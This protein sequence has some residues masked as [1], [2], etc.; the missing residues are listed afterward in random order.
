MSASLKRTSSSAAPPAKKQKKPEP[1][2][3]DPSKV[4]RVQKLRLTAEA[5]MYMWRN[6]AL[7]NGDDDQVHRACESIAGTN[8]ENH[9][10]FQDVEDWE[11][12]K[13]I[14]ETIPVEPRGFEWKSSWEEDGAYPVPDDAWEVWGD[15]IQ[16][17]GMLVMLMRDTVHGFHSWCE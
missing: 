11:Y 2:E 3:P 7:H 12:E 1:E 14:R 17:R 15:W 10:I 6:E 16:L 8:Y 4:A 9:P 13:A 5:V